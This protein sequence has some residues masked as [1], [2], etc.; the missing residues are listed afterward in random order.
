MENN[1]NGYVVKLILNG[2]FSALIS[3][4]F[5]P[6]STVRPENKVR[7]L[8]YYYQFISVNVV[9]GTSRGG[10]AANLVTNQVL[11]GRTS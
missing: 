11:E 2:I 3:D 10:D 6:P 4:K 8:D 5:R 1:D 9:D 7:P